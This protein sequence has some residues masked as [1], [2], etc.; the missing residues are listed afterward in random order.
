MIRFTSDQLLAK[1]LYALEE[2]LEKCAAAPAPPS[3][4][5]RFTLAWLAARGAERRPFDA[6]WREATRPLAPG[7]D[8]G[9]AA[10]ARVQAATAALNGIYR[11]VG[12]ERS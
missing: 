9:A 10:I 11:A 2:T 8:R 12:A 3:G 5:L 1:A 7:E 4:A 6:F